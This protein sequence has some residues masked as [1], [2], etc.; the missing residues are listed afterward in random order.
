MATERTGSV[1]DTSAMTPRHGRL[2]RQSGVAH[3]FRWIALGMAVVL[4][5][6]VGVV[7]FSILRFTTSIE[8]VDL[9]GDVPP[10]QAGFAPYDGGFTILLVGSDQRE[11]QRQVHCEGGP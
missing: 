11:G 10:A 1:V 8:T 4:V 9:A 7:G 3:V 6:L 5:A 2:R